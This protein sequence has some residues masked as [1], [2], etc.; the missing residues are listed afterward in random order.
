[1]IKLYGAPLSPYYIKV[2]IALL[3]KAVNFEEVPT[4]PSQDPALLD[5]S[6]MGKIPFVEINGH[7]IAESSAIIEWL[8]D[9][10]PT[11]SLLPPTPNG[12]ALARQLSLMFDLYLTSACLP[13][14]RHRLFGAPL[15]AAA[16]DEAEIGIGRALRAVSRL[17]RFDPWLAGDRFT[18]ADISAAS[19][20]PLVGWVERTLARDLLSPFD[21]VAPYL[22]RL[23]E[24]PSVHE[25]WTQRQA[26]LE[27]WL[28]RSAAQH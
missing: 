17:L 20:L 7:A 4:R 5:K 24:R 16:R 12:R 28:A 22:A 1:M 21:W 27:Q 3:E 11:G 18:I 6:P 19:I 8:E 9:A 2:K 14:Q 26:A 25:A 10:Y 13:V 23:G 15:D